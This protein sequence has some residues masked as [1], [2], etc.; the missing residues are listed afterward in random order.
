MRAASSFDMAGSRLKRGSCVRGF[1]GGVRA[2]SQSVGVLLT[3]EYALRQGSG[4]PGVPGTAR[5]VPA[6]PNP[7][8]QALPSPNHQLPPTTS[9]FFLP[10]DPLQVII[11]SGML[12][13]NPG[14]KPFQTRKCLRM[15]DRLGDQ[16]E[17]SF[18]WTD[19]SFGV[20]PSTVHTFLIR[21]GSMG[22]IF[23]LGG[24]GQCGGRSQITNHPSCGPGR[25]GHE[26]GRFGPGRQ[27]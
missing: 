6:L 21:G 8:K 3:Y 23:R 17:L 13:Q 25:A 5:W 20:L 1:C 11:K 24:R 18:P 10:P 15:D 26:P 16:Q 4:C 22:P 19:R 14:F 9:I 27:R 7:A 2:R 12:H